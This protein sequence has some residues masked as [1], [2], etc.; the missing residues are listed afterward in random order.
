M[1]G[2]SLPKL[3]VKKDTKNRNSESNREK[4][5][6]PSKKKMLKIEPG[7]PERFG[8]KPSTPMK[9][10]DNTK[11]RQLAVDQNLSPRNEPDT[12]NELVTSNNVKKKPPI[13]DQLA[14]RK[15]KMVEGLHN[16][17]NPVTSE[18]KDTRN[19]NHE[20]GRE[21]KGKPSKKKMLTI[22]P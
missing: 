11:Q 4:K 5:G 3:S 20:A 15:P 1:D 17:S 10:G 12:G 7:D 16:E 8:S 19:G 9:L 21:R 22:E 14:S 2:A 13:K 18:K 6:K